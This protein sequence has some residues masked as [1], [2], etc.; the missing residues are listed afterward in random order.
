M[1]EDARQYVD[2]VARTRGYVLEYHEKMAKQDFPVLR[3]A[4][5]GSRST[6]A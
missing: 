6:S 4:T 1:T 3:A 2:D 5:S